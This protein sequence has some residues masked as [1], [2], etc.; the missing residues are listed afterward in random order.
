M[1]RGTNNQ[2]I[3]G[4][5][6]A[7]RNSF[8]GQNLW[9]SGLLRHLTDSTIR[10]TTKPAFWKSGGRAYGSAQNRDASVLSLRQVIKERIRSRKHGYMGC[11]WRWYSVRNIRSQRPPAQSSAMSG[12][13]TSLLS[14]RCILLDSRYV[15]V[16]WF[17]GSVFSSILAPPCG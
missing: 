12:Q 16:G 13:T 7:V 1:V 17:L 15:L 2:M 8:P 14:A 6:E 10:T 5:A 9:L 4:V 3:V 11:C